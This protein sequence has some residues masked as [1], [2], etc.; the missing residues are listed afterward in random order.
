[1]V[2]NVTRVDQGLG[3]HSNPSSSPAS[4]LGKPAARNRDWVR[5][6]RCKPSQP[7]PGRDLPPSNI[8]SNIP[9]SLF[10]TLDLVAASWTRNLICNDHCH[11][12][13]QFFKV[14]HAPRPSL[15]RLS[16]FSFP[17][18]WRRC[19]GGAVCHSRRGHKYLYRRY[20]KSPLVQINHKGK[21][22]KTT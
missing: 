17:R 2:D 20:F 18:A 8:S 22:G 7:D 12:P 9:E 16:R 15:F 5:A 4:G 1:M 19:L 10:L 6:L 21:A 13:D 14:G 11:L 3:L